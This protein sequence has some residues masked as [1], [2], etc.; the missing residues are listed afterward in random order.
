MILL[1]LNVTESPC[2]AFLRDGE[3]SPPHGTMPPPHGEELNHMVRHPPTLPMP[4]PCHPEIQFS[5]QLELIST[6]NI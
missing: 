3:A 6:T 1:H 2:I 5:M 4:H